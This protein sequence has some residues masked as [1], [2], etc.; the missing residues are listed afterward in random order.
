MNGESLGSFVKGLNNLDEKN[1]R[2]VHDICNALFIA[3]KE[4]ELSMPFEFKS[5]GAWGVV[6]P[7][8]IQR[9]AFNEIEPNDKDKKLLGVGKKLSKYESKQLSCMAQ[10]LLNGDA[11]LFE[12]EAR[13]AK[14][15]INE[16]G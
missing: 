3:K 4:L 6:S 12:D 5:K 16:L 15:L 11:H 14:E 10:F 7:Q 1:F 9:V 2:N 13:Q 8:I